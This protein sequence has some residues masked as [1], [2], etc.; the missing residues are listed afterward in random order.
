MDSGA[1]E[2]LDIERGL[3]VECAVNCILVGATTASAR[4]S[5]PLFAETTENVAG[6]NRHAS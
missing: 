5:F 1:G 2:G 3:M 4:W 6:V